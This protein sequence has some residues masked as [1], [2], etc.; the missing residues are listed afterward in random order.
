M[1]QY[2]DLLNYVL[3]Y[4][5]TKPNRTGEDTISTFHYSY[6]LDVSKKFPML[7]GK[8]VPWKSVLFEMLWF[9]S[10]DNKVDWLHKHNV[11]FWDPWI[12]EVETQ[13]MSA[14][15]Y[16]WHCGRGEKVTEK[17]LP[18]AY[19]LYWRK[20]PRLGELSDTMIMSDK[21]IDHSIFDQF[22]Q[23]IYRLKNDPNDRRLV[24]TNWYPPRAFY[25]KLPPCH[26]ASVFNTQYNTHGE[27]M[28]C[29]SMTQRSCD[30]PVGVPFNIA[31]Y[32]LLL[33]IVAKLTGMKP[34]LFG[35]TLVDAH[36]YKNQL[37]G[38]EEYLKRELRELPEFS[39]ADDLSTLEDL[40]E[41]IRNGTTEEI[42]DTF[43]LW[44]YNPH[45]KIDFPVMV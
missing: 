19:G 14:D 10:G 42:M 40:D 37:E 8:H 22:Y 38:V 1:K 29:L 18:E 30:V 6:V 25:A 39:I 12:E 5:T 44:N 26:F 24:L 2:K 27:P 9:L 36:I 32:A 33:H 3:E 4:G 16:C 35:Y 31:S 43:K 11:H 13:P 21:I 41:L 28:L 34:G 7:T 20:Y 17:H 45:P 23:I 15:G